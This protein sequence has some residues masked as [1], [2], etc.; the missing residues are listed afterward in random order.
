M[1]YIKMVLKSNEW[2]ISY[3][4]PYYPTWDIWSIGAWASSSQRTVGQVSIWDQSRQEYRE[5][6][7]CEKIDVEEI[8]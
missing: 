1:A 7:V 3:S 5:Q 8:G 6:I 2:G 4:S